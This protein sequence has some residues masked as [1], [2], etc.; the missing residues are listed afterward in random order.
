MSLSCHF[1]TE[2]NSLAASMPSGSKAAIAKP[3]QEMKE[4]SAIVN[5]PPTSHSCLLRTDSRTPRTRA[6]SFE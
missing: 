5:L 1:L 2:G 4:R 3:F 6:T